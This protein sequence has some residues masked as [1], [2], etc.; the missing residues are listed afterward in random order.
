MAVSKKQQACVNRYNAKNY[1]RINYSVRKGQ[2]EKIKAAADL[3][4]LSVNAYISKAIDAQM[5]R[6]GIQYDPEEKTE[7]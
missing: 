1:D 2:K 3:A 5:Q 7:E 4:G 6:D